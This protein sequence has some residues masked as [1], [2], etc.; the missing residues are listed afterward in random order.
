V[1]L[2]LSDKSTDVRYWRGDLSNNL[3]DSAHVKK[4][5]TIKGVG[6]LDLKKT[7]SPKPA[8]VGV[9]AEI[10]TAFG[11]KQLVYKKIDLPYNDLN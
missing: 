6:I 11:N 3:F 2:E 8:S 9:I 4:I 1:S 10:L 7:S 5:N